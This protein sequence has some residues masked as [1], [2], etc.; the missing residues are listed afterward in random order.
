MLTEINQKSPTSIILSSTLIRICQKRCRFF[1]SGCPTSVPRSTKVR[2][3]KRPA[4]H[5]SVSCQI[6]FLKI[7][8]L[9]FDRSTQIL[10][11]NRADVWQDFSLQLQI[12]SNTTQHWLQIKLEKMLPIKV[13]LTALA[14]PWPWITCELWSGTT[15]MQ[16]FKVNGQS[17]PKTEWK[18]RDG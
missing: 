1:Y 12:W 9:L 6:S 17:I 11:H 3:T 16:K 13:G 8:C 15:H 4:S 7:C 2:P 10:I 14:W 5:S 18:Q